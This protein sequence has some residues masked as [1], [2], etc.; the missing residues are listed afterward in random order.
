VPGDPADAVIWD[1]LIARTGEDSRLTISFLAFL[2]IACLL[3]AIARS[4]TRR[5]PWSGDGAGPGVRPA[6]RAW[7][8]VVLRR[9]DLIRRGSNALPDRFPGRYGDHRAVWLDRISLGC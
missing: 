3:A 6:G 2:S 9:R 8:S 4:P 1:E 7:R 5:S